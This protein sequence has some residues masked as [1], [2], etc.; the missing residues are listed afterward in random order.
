MIRI[1]EDRLH[2]CASRWRAVCLVLLIVFA[3]SFVL[4]APWW[5]ELE[6]P[7]LAELRP[8]ATGDRLPEGWEVLSGA[9]KAVQEMPPDATPE[10]DQL[11][12]EGAT[13]LEAQGRAQL[14]AGSNA[15]EGY[16][17]TAELKLAPGVWANLSAACAREGNTVLPGYGAGIMGA[18]GKPFELATQAWNRNGPIL[19]SR[20][21]TVG[22]ITKI[23][24][25]PLYLKPR[26]D[27]W[28]D[29][30]QRKNQQYVDSMTDRWTKE[31]AGIPG[32]PDRWLR[33]RIEI[34]P[35]QA[36]MWADGLLV[37]SAD[38]PSWVR[39]GICLEMNKGQ[40]LRLL[41]V[42]KLPA[43]SRGYLPLDLTACANGQAIQGDL[44]DGYGF[45]VE[46]MPAAGRFIS[47]GGVPFYWTA[48]AG[49][50]DSLDISKTTFRNQQSYI[51]T[52]AADHD[53]RRVMLRAPKRQY[54][55][56]AVVAAAD[57]V[58]DAGNMLNVR[59]FKA[60]RGMVLDA[61]RPIP[62]WDAAGP[63]PDAVPLPAGAMLNGGKPSDKEGRLWLV[64]IPLD[65]GSFQDFLGSPNESIL[66]L[67]LTGPPVQDGS[68]A[69]KAGRVGVHI[70]AA[71]LIEAPVEMTV[72]SAEAGHVFVQPQP[73]AFDV[74]LRNTTAQPQAGSLEV[75]A[76]DFYG[77]EQ[78]QQVRYALQPAAAG[79]VSVTV[80][81]GVRGLH[82]LDVR[83]PGAN[84]AVSVRRRTTYA[85]LPPDTRKAGLD[86]PFGMWVFINS[87]YGAGAEEA[88]SL[89]SK[90]GVRW[91]SVPGSKEVAAAFT[92]RYRIHL[93]YSSRVL[94]HE[95]PEGAVKALMAGPETH[96]VPPFQETAISGNH[97]HYFPPELLEDGKPMPLTEVEE[98]RFKMMWEKSSAYS[99]A[100]RDG[101]PDVKLVF[102]AGYPQFINTFLSR[103][104]PRKYF[105][106]L[107]LDFIGDRM[108]MFFY[109]REAARHYGYGDVPMQI[110]E[111][112]Y[113]GSARGYH[114]SRISEERQ[115]NLY[116]QGFLR[117]MAMGIER[118]GSAC[119]IWD[120]GSDYHWSGY[121]NVGVCHMAPELNP[122]PGYVAYGTMSLMLD[123]AHFTALVP[124]GSPITYALR[125]DGPR[126][127]VYALWAGSGTRT[128]GFTVP[129]GAKPRLID[130][131]ANDRPFTVKNGQVI[132]SLDQ[133]PLW[134]TEAG[135]IDRFAAG[136]AD[137]GNAPEKTQTIARFDTPDAWTFDAAPCPEI[138]AKNTS[139]PVKGGK[140]TLAPT[141]GRRPGEKALELLL[142]NEP[143]ASPHR[144]HYATLRPAEKP[145]IPAG[146]RELGIWVKGNGGAWVD[147]ELTDADGKRFTS[148]SQPLS[149]NFGFQYQGPHAFDGWKYVAFAL[150]PGTPMFRWRGVRRNEIPRLPATI[151]GVYL[152]QYPKILYGNALVDPMPKEW[153]LGEIVVCGDATGAEDE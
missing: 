134:L 28:I 97:Y 120:P 1:P 103:G 146:S 60:G 112:F 19:R 119:E 130:S 102:G 39:G 116:I 118:F 71:T 18:K 95:T 87:H 99:Q 50:P 34:T 32:Y 75:R 107:A 11:S 10:T 24:Q 76:T 143:A 105:D 140:F 123:Q 133:E 94:Q 137:Y 150:Q 127:P 42:E 53:P 12:I 64:T 14:W 139:Q 151:T 115:S 22:N 96:Y 31:F 109:T 61:C 74:H 43:A 48:G 78:V 142:K 131:Q 89:M 35:G 117:G 21:S 57:T 8:D 67:D 27:P 69:L 84:G 90:I 29:S 4:P 70:L 26:I 85:V 23:R 101:L 147:F 77:K 17:V 110:L 128:I 73:P 38:N 132:L 36:R 124:T 15:W 136:P 58:R 82:Y 129:A 138:E 83:L 135:I 153:R 72:T 86:S 16:A 88:G 9:L 148:V 3:G 5:R 91:S 30:R 13:V 66:E 126:G 25:F 55:A 37:A 2:H 145:V 149:Y 49:G 6:A 54:T 106:S 62:R 68:P 65:P 45:A 93:K 113:V 80:P 122:K 92:E 100:I 59:M 44:G 20:V 40:R 63:Q 79:V 108:N 81:A 7:V 152:Q 41:R 104:Y 56:L 111:G 52:S 114:L 141:E 51:H 46:G 33:L 98:E 144:F 47:V 121:G 125:F